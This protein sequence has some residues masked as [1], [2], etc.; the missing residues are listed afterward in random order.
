MVHFKT[1]ASNLVD[2]NQLGWL[3]MDLFGDESF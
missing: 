3:S 1:K 2:L